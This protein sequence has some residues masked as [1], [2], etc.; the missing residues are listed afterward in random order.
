[1]L[2]IP[3]NIIQTAAECN[4]KRFEKC[5]FE[6]KY[7]V[8]LIEGDATDEQLKAAFEFIYAQYV[9]F[10]GL[11]Q[12][13]EFEM[14]AY[15]DSLDKRI[16]TIKRFVELQKLFI[17]EFNMPYLPA[18]PM[19]AKYGHNLYWNPD[20]H[21]IELFEKKLDQIISKEGKY[22]IKVQA[23]VNE[24]VE[25]RKKR[26]NKE[27]TLLE[28]RRNFITMLNRLGQA[29][30]VIDKNTTSMEE[31]SYMVRDNRD[32]QEAERSAQQNKRK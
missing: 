15:I 6:G 27:F 31:I 26:I 19:V 25:F 7:R 16:Q 18:F 21:N 10:S 23:K 8:L 29:R 32:Q 9:D 20:V 13:R 12:S 5:A 24:L 22:D 11:Y 14:V 3:D 4:V 2:E 1:M 17:K 30:F 28:S